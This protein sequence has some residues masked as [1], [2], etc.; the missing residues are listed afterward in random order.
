MHYRCAIANVPMH[1]LSLW[2]PSRGLTSAQVLLQIQVTHLVEKCYC[3]VPKRLG[4]APR[5]AVRASCVSSQARQRLCQDPR[6]GRYSKSGELCGRPFLESA[7]APYP[8]VFRLRR[9]R[10]NIFYTL[11]NRRIHEFLVLLT[12]QKQYR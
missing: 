12:I 2:M 4:A 10:R 3:H 5:P 1:I 7:V 9:Q 6:K 11:Y 8:G